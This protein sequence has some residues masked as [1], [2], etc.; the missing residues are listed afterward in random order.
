MVPDST[1]G[2]HRREPRHGPG[3]HVGPEL[4]RR[5]ER[6]E[7]RLL[8]EAVSLH[9]LHVTSEAF[10]LPIGGGVAVGFDANLPI[11]K[12]I[13]AGFDDV[14]REDL[15]R[16]EGAFSRVGVP[17]IVELC[18][19]A[20]VA[21]AADLA[22][23][24]YRLTAFENA[25]AL[26]LSNDPVEPSIGG[27]QVRDVTPGALPEW[28]RVVAEGFGAPAGGALERMLGP[29]MGATPRTRC[30]LAEIDG[31]S[32]GGAA[33]RIEDGVALSFAT[34]TL[35]RFRQRGVQRALVETT[36]FAA[37]MADADLV[38]ATTDPGSQ[39][40]RTFERAG[41][42]VAYSRAILSS[43]LPQAAPPASRSSARR[44]R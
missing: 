6:A 31:E 39:S 17:T 19:L 27:V 35:P 18:P 11:N 23:R 36:I 30:L 32:A 4:A 13:G 42:R 10:A 38:V 12:V 40:Q 1:T 33:V 8:E 16:I 22:M 43:W 24:Q 26:P 20:R 29:L 5:I 15:D 7:G 14:A 34:S 41:F 37:K 3:W 44:R 25:L 28:S 21:F 9:R 2:D